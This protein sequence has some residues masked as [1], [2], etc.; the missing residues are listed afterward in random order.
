MGIYNI[1]NSHNA[2]MEKRVPFNELPYNVRKKLNKVKD[3][4]LS[5]DERAEGSEWVFR[6]IHLD[7]LF[8][9]ASTTPNDRNEEERIIKYKKEYLE[10]RCCPTL[11]VWESMGILI[12]GYHHLTA[13]REAVDED[14]TII[15]I[16]D[17]WVLVDLF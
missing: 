4:W 16:I 1:H 17:C 5:K 10:R 12:D 8:Y 6:K 9:I 2:I 13:F 7:D 11:I 14:N 15:P 3:S